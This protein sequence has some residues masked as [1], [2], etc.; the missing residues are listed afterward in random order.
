M[1]SMASQDDDLLMQFAAGD[2]DAFVVFYRRHLGAMLGFFLRRTGD[3]ELTADLTAAVFAAALI[4]AGGY[5]SGERPELAWLYGIAAHKREGVR[6]FSS[7]CGPVTR[8]RARAQLDRS[9]YRR[10]GSTSGPDKVVA[11]EQPAWC[12]MRRLESDSKRTDGR[13]GVSV[14]GGGRAAWSGYGRR[15][16]R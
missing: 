5:R 16:A 3:P 13:C 10:S 1:V 9:R 11:R 14:L 15:M 6:S 8:S 7:R 4:G 2:P 12:A